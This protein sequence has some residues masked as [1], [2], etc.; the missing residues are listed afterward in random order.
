MKMIKLNVALSLFAVATAGAGC[1]RTSIGTHEFR[2]TKDV[3]YSKPA[4]GID[5]NMQIAVPRGLKAP[6]PAILWLHGGGWAF[7]KKELMK[8]I[9]EFTA[10][11][12]YVSATAQYRLV[13]QGKFPA[14]VQDAAAAIR[15]LRKNASEYN[16]DPERI[17]IGGESA[18][19]HIALLVG[20]SDD[21]ALIGSE[22]FTGVSSCV[23]CII[24]IYGPT[25]LEPM[26][27]KPS[28]AGKSL[29][30]N[31]VGG[32]PATVPELYKA[33]SPINHVTADSP[34]ILILHGDTDW[35]VPYSQAEALAR[36]CTERG[37]RFELG[38]VSGANHAW[39]GQPRGRNNIATLP[40]IA[41][42]LGRTLN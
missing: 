3:V 16:I 18:G 38:C 27:T 39:I 10:S 29:I 36:V 37:A 2:W 32:D 17:A 8:P 12:G 28:L 11:L 41:N 35:V 25:H 14:P 4:D 24:D 34:P 21:P 31:F 6:A 42:F 40:V 1:A 23:S 9:S 5:L 19:G 13:K 15:F 22:P 7:G 20:L 26:Y 30:G 33:A